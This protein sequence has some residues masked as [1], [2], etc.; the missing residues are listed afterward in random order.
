MKESF[1]TNLAKSKK[2][3]TSAIATFN[4]MK[5]AKTEE[6]AAGKTTVDNKETE[7]ANADDQKAQSK[8]DLADTTAQMEA[9]KVFLADVQARCAAM[10]KQFAERTKIRQEETTAVSEALAI[11]QDDDA[12]DLMSRSTFLQVSASR[13]AARQRALAQARV[14]VAL[15]A[16]ARKF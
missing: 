9:D 10:D 2:D 13:R 6:I 14:A 11:L 7:L 8:E 1:E 15:R 16:A 5:A 3:E 4:D 12:K